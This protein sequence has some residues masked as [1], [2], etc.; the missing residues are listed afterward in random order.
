MSEHIEIEG[1][2]VAFTDNAILFQSDQDQ[3]WVAKSQISDYSGDS[4]D[5]A[6]SIFMNEWVATQKGFV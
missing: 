5:T 3:S 6:D 1:E 2:V 4:I